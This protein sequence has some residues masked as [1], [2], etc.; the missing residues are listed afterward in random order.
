MKKKVQLNYNE[1]LDFSI[2]GIVS[3][4]KDYRFIW[5]INET[6]GTNF[7]RVEDHIA[8][9][10]KTKTEQSFS[11]YIYEDNNSYIQYRILMNKGHSGYLLD[12]LKNIDFLL[13]I[14]GEEHERELSLLKNKIQK[15][16]NVQAVFKL[17]P[18]D[19]KNPERLLTN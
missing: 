16:E 13:L 17:D 2:L 5:N 10:K 4:D 14:K 15:I 1:G 3:F 18:E 19:L 11:N 12:S 9:H 8:I 6:L 7:T